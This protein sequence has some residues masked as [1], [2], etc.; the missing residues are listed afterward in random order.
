MP[1]TYNENNVARLKHLASLGTRVNSELGAT[2]RSASVSGNTVS[3]FNSKDGTGTAAFTFDFPEEM[4]LS[5]TGTE[6]VD[7]FTFSS[8]TYPGAT[9]PNLNGKPVLVLAVRG[10][11][12]TPTTNYS[13]VSLERLIDVYTAGDNSIN[14]NGYNVSV[15]R[16]AA[17]GNLIE[18]KND[19]LYVGSD[20]TKADKVTGATAGNIATLD[21]NGN[22]ADSGVTFASDADVN[23]MITNVFGASS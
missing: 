15:K 22:L 8:A 18:L 4:F 21:A 19:G 5:Q 9:D 6:L 12:L 16:S 7:N 13:F 17:T 11:A 14:I 2:F 3:F 1:E 10:N 23:A 20:D